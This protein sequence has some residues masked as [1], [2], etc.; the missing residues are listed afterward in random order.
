VITRRTIVNLV[1]FLAVT[2]ALVAYGFVDLLGNPL[3]QPTRVSAVFPDAS[4]IAPGLTVALYGVDVGSVTGVHLEPAG[5]VVDMAIQPGSNV[6]GNVEAT[7]DL[8]NDLGQQQIDLVVT[9]HGRSRPLLDGAVLPAVPNAVPTDVGRV[10]QTASALLSALPVQDL[11]TILAQGAQAFAGRAADVDTLVSASRQFSSELLT[12][13]QQ[14]EALLAQS[15][16]VLD[17]LASVGPQ[18]RADLAQTSVLADVL[19]AHRYDL[20]RLLDEGASATQ[21]ADELVQA[22]N[23][24][25]GCLLH[26]GADVLSNLGAPVQI[27]YLGRALSTEQ[28]F[29][30]AVQAISPTG[31]STSLFPG[32]PASDDTEWLRTRLLLPPMQPSASQYAS[33]TGLPVVMPGAACVTP[34]GRG[35]GPATQSTPSVPVAGARF[36][37]APASASQVGAPGATTHEEQQP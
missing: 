14:F 32:D 15:P 6:P 11:N 28:W 24:N 36:S 26:D 20:V 1:A 19:T 22:E 30:G 18:L 31:P 10:V 21:V 27:G 12:Y 8:A 25:L 3:A 33:P 7:I 23:P 37:P 2:L 4:G 13:Q 34:L 17:T 29:F 16:A 35:V 9:G 5:A